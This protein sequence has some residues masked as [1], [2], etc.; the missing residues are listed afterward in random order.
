MFEHEVIPVPIKNRKTKEMD[1][2]RA[3]E[4]I[5]ARNRPVP[6]KSRFINLLFL[7]MTVHH[8]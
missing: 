2:W 6:L 5:R 4:H 7:A 8:A 1:D 3:D